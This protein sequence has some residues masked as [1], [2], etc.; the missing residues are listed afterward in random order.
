MTELEF[1]QK[2]IE[3]KEQKFATLASLKEAYDQH[4]KDAVAAIGDCE[5]QLH[6]LKEAYHANVIATHEAYRQAKAPLIIEREKTVEEMRAKGIPS[7]RDAHQCAKAIRNFLEAKKY[8]RRRFRF[9]D[10]MMLSV[11]IEPTTDNATENETTETA[12]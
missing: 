5:K 8:D 9:A 7:S 3:L 6:E 2:M 1:N 10:G 11:K 4:R 12:E